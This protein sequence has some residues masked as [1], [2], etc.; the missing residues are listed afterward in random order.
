[1]LE[2][3]F[4]SLVSLLLTVVGSLGYIGIFLLMTIESTIIPFPAEIIL[5]PA[6]VL[7]ARGELSFFL[8]LAM[9]T[10]GSLAGALINYFFAFHLGRRAINRLLQKYEH[11][12]YIR[13]SHIL[14]AER[15]FTNHGEIATFIGRLIPAFRSFV[16][17]PAGFTRMNLTRFCIFTALGAG[18]WSAL[19]IYLG[20]LFGNNLELIRLYL[21]KIVLVLVILLVPL[22]IIYWRWHISRQ[23]RP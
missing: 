10:L 3:F 16:S 23:R 19:L 1:M 7:V 8:V 14:K 17:L 11:V 15:F 9:A 22:L 4:D 6:G 12:L 20:M 13:Y 5:V 21:N 18:L 2:S